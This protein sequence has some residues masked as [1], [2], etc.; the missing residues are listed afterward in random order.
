M[1]SNRTIESL[2]LYLKRK[3]N[4]L[5]DSVIDS[6]LLE[7]ISQNDSIN[8]EAFMLVKKVRD[9]NIRLAK[10]VKQKF[11][12]RENQT[13]AYQLG[14]IIIDL[15]KEASLKKTVNSI[16]EL[17][18]EYLNRIEKLD[19]G[20]EKKDAVF[21]FK[22]A[23]IKSMLPKYIKS[24]DKKVN[25]Y[26]KGKI[27]LTNIYLLKNKVSLDERNIRED[28]ESSF[29]LDDKKSE[30]DIS[31]NYSHELV[32]H[33]KKDKLPVGY[34]LLESK[35]YSF[36]VK[37]GKGYFDFTA[38]NDQGKVISNAA[39][40][41]FKLYDSEGEYILPIDNIPINKDVGP[42]VYI[43][44]DSLSNPKFNEVMVEFDSPNV[45][46][47]DLCF[48]PWKKDVK[49]YV[50][51][52]INASFLEILDESSK[53]DSVTAFIEELEPEDKVIMLYTTAPYIE[54]ETLELRPNR[55]AK[56]YI[57][58]G[59]KVIFFSFSRVPDDLVMPEKY[60]KNLFQCL[61]EDIV[62]VSSIIAHKE[63]SEKV[64]IC[65]SFPDVL[66]LTTMN[67]LK[68]SSWKLVYE[69]RDDME[70]FNRVG[71]SKWYDTK[72]ESSVINIVDK[73]VTVSPRL[74]QKAK[75]MAC[76]PN[77][78]DSKVKVIQN[79]APDAL[80]DKTK[81]LRTLEIARS[82]N[83]SNKVGY[84][85]H[86]TPAWFDW[87]LVINSAKANPD[88]IYEIIGHGMPKGLSLPENIIYLGPKSHD[89]FI[90][91][92][93]SWRIGLIPFI[94]SPLTYGVD[95]NKIYEYLAVGLM[96]VTADMGSVRQCPATYVYEKN[97]EF[98]SLFKKALNTTYNKNTVRK[99]K[100]YVNRSRWSIRAE[101]LLKE[102]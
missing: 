80:I 54:H 77:M 65:S 40:V 39:L 56:E 64:F 66:A 38:F 41:S 20:I 43:E 93:K 18:K 6:I 87:S 12:E 85:G 34:S 24:F 14:A 74:A 36:E 3:Y 27:S 71:Y 13:I 26:S 5:D 52:D 49:T 84:I 90:E 11:S 99:I 31:P 47:L 91:I 79:A 42:Y 101:Q 83:G 97:D 102:I 73:V 88:I 46:R 29:D 68:L 98:D 82:R 55:M 7:V 10:E 45:A 94:K 70:E 33:Q 19:V 78:D 21:D 15:F 100:N 72:L 8:D 23:P 76:V 51:D 17:R 22:G 16:I 50:E 44:S 75:V 81:Q 61:F 95:P 59:Y 48:H 92:S 67:K 30:S 60:G 89:E 35:T 1:H 86:L 4:F 28:Y 37:P 2:R 32:D 58:L 57:N 25:E 9:E 62:R 96:V 63:L 53:T 69:I